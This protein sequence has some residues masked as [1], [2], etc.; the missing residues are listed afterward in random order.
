[1]TAPSTTPSD[2]ILTYRRGLGADHRIDATLLYSIEKQSAEMDS[3]RTSGLPYESQRWYNLGSGATVD[4]VASSISQWALQSYMGRLNYTFRDRYLFTLTGRLDGSSRL[5]PGKKYSFF[6]S[7]AFAWRAVD[8]S[9]GSAFGPINSLKLRTSY[10]RT[11]NTSVDPYST[12]GQLSRSIYAWGTA[13]A[14]GFR[15][16]NLENPDLGW[17]KTSQVDAGVD[18]GMWNNR[19]TGTIDTYRANTTDLLLDRQLPASTG[20]TK[21]TQNIGETR[22]TG[23]EVSL[24]HSTIDGWH[25][26][27]W[28]NDVNWS[29]NHNTIINAGQFDSTG[30]P[31]DDIGNRWFIGQPIDANSSTMHVWYDYKMIGIWQ[32]DEAAA[33]ASFGAKPGDIKIEDYNGDGKIDASDRQILGNT[34]PKW[35]GSWNTRL[36]Y[37]RMDFAVQ[38]VTRQGFMIQNLFQTDNS[39]LAG[40]Y[41]GIAVDYW[42]PTNPSNTEPRPNK[43]QEGPTYG[44]SRAYEDGSFT[45]VRNITLGVTVPPRF[46]QSIGGE[47]LRLY[48]TAQNPFTFTNSTA[49]DPEGRANA[50]TPAYRSI[51]I[52]ANVG[53]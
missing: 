7:A 38:V 45:R 31:I 2:N 41:N 39:T 35:T 33:A 22:N 50:G 23:I 13:P 11:G 32:L 4:A 27:R 51:L 16:G 3:L 46:V 1:M 47:S 44:G 53:F 21:I 10:G 26:L 20:Y 19:L 48:S 6:P 9:F 28:T 43:N 24:S 8:E 14:F 17:E 49:L 34:Y 18:F 40:R 29:V 5:A 12:L 15:P 30:T 37:G 52:G 42:T 25:G 36:D